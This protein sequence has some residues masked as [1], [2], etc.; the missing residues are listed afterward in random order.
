MDKFIAAAN[1]NVERFLGDLDEDTA[2]RWILQSM[3]LDEYDIQY[4]ANYIFWEFGLSYSHPRRD[5]ID[6]I[7]NSL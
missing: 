1:R 5:Q 6:R 2:I 3:E 4:G 7:L